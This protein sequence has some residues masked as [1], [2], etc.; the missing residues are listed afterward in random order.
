MD[1]HEDGIGHDEGLPHEL[2]S[3]RTASAIGGGVALLVLGLVVFVGTTREGAGATPTRVAQA[4][5][6][7]I[8][9]VAHDPV[10]DHT[11]EHAAFDC[12]DR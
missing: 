8:A 5:T 3:E 10:V 1:I 11:R 2:S 9:D 4:R 7:P 6:A 12:C